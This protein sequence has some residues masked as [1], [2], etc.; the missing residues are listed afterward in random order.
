MKY[1]FFIFLSML[2]LFS[3]S[4]KKIDGEFEVLNKPFKYTQLDYSNYGLVH[5]FV[6]VVDDNNEGSKI[7]RRIIGRL[8]STKHLYHTYYYIL[9][10]PQDLKS[11]KGKE[12]VLYEFL[13]NLKPCENLFVLMQNDI[14]SLYVK[15]INYGEDVLIAKALVFDINLENITSFLFSKDLM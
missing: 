15:R 7:E 8:R 2:F 14:S 10:L 9:K 5:T 6:I 11:V 1:L 3:F 12:T 13:K 4:Q